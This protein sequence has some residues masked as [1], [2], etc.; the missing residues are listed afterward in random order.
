M[1]VQPTEQWVQTDFRV[2]TAPCAAVAA[3][4]FVTVPPMA[5]I[6]ARPP[7]ARPL[8]RR[9]A[10]RST[11]FPATS[12][13]ILVRWGR[14]A[15]PLVF[16]LSMFS[17]PPGRTPRGL[18]GTKVDHRTVGR[19][20]TCR[21]HGWVTLS[22]SEPGRVEIGARMRGV[23]NPAG[24]KIGLGRF[25]LPTGHCRHDR[26]SG[27]AGG[28]QFEKI[29]TAGAILGFLRHESPLSLV[30]AVARRVM[31]IPPRSFGSLGSRSP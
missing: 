11:D 9:N 5:P 19:H 8:P 28:G 26:N 2:W 29:A 23:L 14:L 31:R 15:T 13:R 27:R 24:C 16:F 22:G 3:L 20:A 7:M 1:T 21:R 4:A 6:A 17:S 18:L 10:R 30:V 25:G 12:D